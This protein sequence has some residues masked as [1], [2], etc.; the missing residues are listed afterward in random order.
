VARTRKAFP[1]REHQRTQ[2]R[3]PFQKA[4]E[5]PVGYAEQAKEKKK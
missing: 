1:Q 3:N 4:K 5:D 2:T